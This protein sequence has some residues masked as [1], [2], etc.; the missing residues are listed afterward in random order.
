[1]AVEEDESPL[2]RLY[3]SSRSREVEDV[4]FSAS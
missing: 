2:K 1:M 3:C 4:V